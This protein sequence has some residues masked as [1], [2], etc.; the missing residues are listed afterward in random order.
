VRRGPR[1]AATARMLTCAHG[2]AGP[3]DARALRDAARG[4]VGQHVADVALRAAACE[5]ARPVGTGCAACGLV[6]ER[7][8]S[9]ALGTCCGQLHATWQQS[10]AR[11]AA[12]TSPIRRYVSS[13]PVA[14][15]TWRHRR[16]AAP[17][18]SRRPSTR[19]RWLGRGL[20][21]RC[22]RIV[23]RS[24]LHLWRRRRGLATLCQRGLPRSRLDRRRRRRRS[25]LPRASGCGSRLRL[26]R[27]LGLRRRRG[28][29]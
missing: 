1:M 9:D 8:T 25:W 29:A 16:R 24:R 5:A 6:R 11:C 18:R 28:P 2:L 3:A 27:R 7:R 22:R 14:S 20:G 4:W 19:G 12:R 10:A 17:R 26:R 23:R 13:F 21:S 15:L